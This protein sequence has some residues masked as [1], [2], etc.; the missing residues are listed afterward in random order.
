M[1]F[2]IG[3]CFCFYFPFNFSELWFLTRIDHVDVIENNIAGSV[4]T[5]QVTLYVHN[6]CPFPKWPAT[7]PNIG[8]PKPKTQNVSSIRT[9]KQITYR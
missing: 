1:Q 6:K 3:V 7:A 5:Y 2:K 4:A 8:Y 9:N